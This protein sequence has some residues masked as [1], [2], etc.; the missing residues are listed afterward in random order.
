[1]QREL[2]Q[3]ALDSLRGGGGTEPSRPAAPDPPRGPAPDPARRRPRA[4][5]AHLG[6]PLPP[7]RRGG[8]ETRERQPR[9]PR[10][11]FPRPAAQLPPG[12]GAGGAAGPPRAARGAAG[13]EA[14]SAAAADSSAIWR[15]PPPFRFSPLSDFAARHAAR[16]RGG[17]GACALGGAKP[18][19]GAPA[20]GRGVSAARRELRAVLRLRG[21]GV[22]PPQGSV[23]GGEGGDE[24][25]EGSREASGKKLG[26]ALA[27]VSEAM[28]AGGSHVGSAVG[29]P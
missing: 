12:S 3:N 23:W 11:A 24:F 21:R 19:P 29:Q 18:L 15:R 10:R 4:R 7:R 20:E 9:G 28:R 13:D 22:P 25:C 5:R 16:M 17:E 8:D 26:R 14:P 6:L 27:H 1:M 2:P